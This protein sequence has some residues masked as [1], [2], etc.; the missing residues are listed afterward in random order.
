MSIKAPQQETNEPAKPRRKRRFSSFR[1]SLWCLEAVVLLAC[2]EHFVIRPWLQ[3][4]RTRSKASAT[5]VPSNQGEVIR[6]LADD[7][8]PPVGMRESFPA[9]YPPQ[10]SLSGGGEAM[11]QRQKMLSEETG[12]P[13]EVVNSIGMKFRLVP[14]GNCLIGSPE[15]EPGHSP[16]EVL[17]Y[18]EFPAPF[19]LG[20]YEVTQAQW[21]AVMGA[22]N[23]PSHF[24]G[25]EQ[26]VE[27]VSWYDCQEFILKLCAMEGLPERTYQLPTEAEWE[28]ACRAGTTTA[29]CFGNSPEKLGQWADFA[30]NN[31][32]RPNKVGRR[33]P[34]A[35]GLFD[36]HGNLWEWCRDTFQ[37]Y[38]GDFTP[39]DEVN[40]WRN[41]RGGN[42]YVDAKACR[43]ANRCRLPGPS[44]GNML[45]FR[46]LRKIELNTE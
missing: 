17:H 26:P 35:L 16:L 31:Y 23:N 5:Q 19:Y 39:L 27:E 34:N 22:E 7:A 3:G 15:E 18:R 14:S 37:N 29:Y 12:L 30:D 13:I 6:P 20:M 38:P 10:V 11:L 32:K 2:L 24:R 42:W 44:V 43:S 21:E 4:D 8:R 36:M 46:V 40:S 41:I 9:W 1:I 33:L 25:A 28:Y 45:G